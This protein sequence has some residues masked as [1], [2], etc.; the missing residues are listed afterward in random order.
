MKIKKSEL[1]QIIQE[2]LEA[3]LG[4]GQRKLNRA[5]QKADY[6]AQRADQKAGKQAARAER[7]LD[8]ADQ[9]AGKQAARA[10]R[11]GALPPSAQKFM[12]DYAAA[13]PSAG[14]PELTYAQGT[15]DIKVEP[16][17]RTLTPDSYTT[18]G[19]SGAPV[20]VGWE[21]DD[22]DAQIAPTRK[23]PPGWSPAGDQEA[24][25]SAPDEQERPAHDLKTGHDP[26]MRP[27]DRSDPSTWEEPS[28]EKE[29]QTAISTRRKKGQSP[30]VDDSPEEYEKKLQARSIGFEEGLIK[31]M[32]QEEL[33]AVLA[34]RNR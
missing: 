31:Q 24:A 14:E 23:R 28:S 11:T 30:L 32:V 19:P 4:K 12:S 8:R 20:D 26:R 34:E 33:E 16:Q 3:V 7:G 5:D 18:R 1:K 9:K 22:P 2:E 17:A 29:R 6:Q 13:T 10:L 27:V 15:G 25:A 21:A